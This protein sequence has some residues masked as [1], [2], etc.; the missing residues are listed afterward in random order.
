MSIPVFPRKGRNDMIGTRLADDIARGKTFATKREFERWERA[1][2]ARHNKDA[3]RYKALM[4]SAETAAQRIHEAM[5]PY[6]DDETIRRVFVEGMQYGYHANSGWSELHAD[7]AS[8]EKMQQVFGQNGLSGQHEDVSAWKKSLVG[9]VVTRAAKSGYNAGG[10]LA[11]SAQSVCNT[12]EQWADYF[13]V[14]SLEYRTVSGREMSI[15]DILADLRDADQRDAVDATGFS[16]DFAQR[17]RDVVDRLVVFY[18][19]HTLRQYRAFLRGFNSGYTEAP[20]AAA[21]GKRAASSSSSSPEKRGRIESLLGDIEQSYS[22]ESGMTDENNATLL[23]QSLGATF[24]RN[25][26]VENK[27]LALQ[28]L[29]RFYDEA[30]SSYSRMQRFPIFMKAGS[31]L[32]PIFTSKKINLLAPTTGEEFD[33]VFPGVMNSIDS[34]EYVS[35]FT[36]PALPVRATILNEIFTAKYGASSLRQSNEDAIFAVK[37]IVNHRLGT[38]VITTLPLQFKDIAVIQ[39]H[40]LTHATSAID[41]NYAP[42]P[43]QREMDTIRACD[44]YARSSVLLLEQTLRDITTLIFTPLLINTMANYVD[45]TTSLKRILALYPPRQPLDPNVHTFLSRY[46]KQLNE[47]WLDSRVYI[48]KSVMFSSDITRLVDDAI[49]SEVAFYLKNPVLENKRALVAGL[50]KYYTTVI[51]VPTDITHDEYRDTVSEMGT[52]KYLRT[53]TR[54]LFSWLALNTETYWPRDLCGMQTVI[55]DV[56]MLRHLREEMRQRVIMVESVLQFDR[57][58]RFSRWDFVDHLARI[59][60]STLSAE[61]SVSFAQ[62]VQHFVELL[63]SNPGTDYD[64]D[65]PAQHFVSPAVHRTNYTV[66][67]DD[68]VGFDSEVIDDDEE[69]GYD[70]DDYSSHHAVDDELDVT[71]EYTPENK[72]KLSITRGFSLSPTS[73]WE[74]D[75]IDSPVSRPSARASSSDDSGSTPIGEC[76]A[77]HAAS[78]LRARQRGVVLRDISPLEAKIEYGMAVR[79]DAHYIGAHYGHAFGPR[80]GCAAYS[81]DEKRTVIAEKN[82]PGVSGV[83]AEYIGAMY[84][85]ARVDIGTTANVVSPPQEP[86]HDLDID[87]TVNYRPR[88]AGHDRETPHGLFFYLSHSFSPSPPVFVSASEAASGKRLHLQYKVR[89]PE[90]TGHAMFNVDGY[91]RLVDVDAEA[92]VNQAGFASIR[93]ADL[94]SNR[95]TSFKLRVP[96]SDLQVAKG[97]VTLTVHSASLPIRTDSTIKSPT[98]LSAEYEQTQRMIREYITANR[99]FYKS[100]PNVVESVQNITVFEYAA[101]E[102]VI[103][104]SLFDS[105]KL[106]PTAE[107]YFTQALEYVLRRRR[108]DADIPLDEWT[109]L[110]KRTKTVALM[111]VMRLYVNYCTYIRDVVDNNREDKRWDPSAIELIE[112]FDYIRQRDAGDCEDFT[113]EILQAAMELKHN[114]RDSLSPAIQE[115]RKIADEFV[116][117]SVLCGVSR[118]AMSL[119]ELSKGRVSL[120]GHECAVAIPSYVFFEALRRN[121]PGH[122]AFELYSEEEQRAGADQQ[123]FVLEGTGCLFPEPRT[124]TDFFKQ[125][126]SAFRRATSV[127]K[128]AEAVVFYHP[129][130]DDGFY[131]Q[132]ITILTPELFLRTGHLG[133]EFLVC[134]RT[135]DGLKRGVPFSLLLDIHS[136]AEIQIVPAPAMSP[137]VFRASSRMD[138]DDFP[139]ISLE[140]GVVTKEMKD[141]C[142]ALTTGRP[143]A[144]QD[145]FQFHVKFSNMISTYIAAIKQFAQQNRLS[146][147][148]LAESVKVSFST[149]QYVGGYTILLF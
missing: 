45:R 19:T 80:L 36:P 46:V 110:D 71:Q 136:H 75:P 33:A 61:E 138:D 143:R 29:A 87:V 114:L 79:G 103:P 55:H 109:A 91:A 135:P 116:F 73:S 124:K 140:P 74:L 88:L 50:A 60:Q 32:R 104:G 40:L 134:S 100:H 56:L 37:L 128:R 16:S 137:E 15:G 63:Q 127:S 84:P 125:V 141:V 117:A 62:T 58:G 123:I 52:G 126:E 131:K 94:V 49:A 2:T 64:S 38:G 68:A 92:C 72:Q 107:R 139:P 118:E 66:G 59:E 76:M 122:P 144:G 112:S 69:D 20:A 6:A 25:A 34:T 119:A 115:M 130:Q 148:C 22:S 70:T 65:S 44:F 4:A 146:V 95:L 18:K 24:Y 101:R 102:G 5:A 1:L 7:R 120:H 41:D 133:F 53:S 106:A 85:D 90:I 43:T 10:N 47:R 11:K 21:S 3:K 132:M 121:D 89:Y 82:A 105:F 17:V 42:T 81:R 97:D 108:P 27:L 9:D 145:F 12:E 31:A 54:A 99:A 14:F 77:C 78:R 51:N 39:R 67:A 35:R 28:L 83:L 57:P 142:A 147:L 96:N 30:M 86:L 13:T 113:R 149:G 48:S 111:D 129:S 93:L 98:A 23:G 8:T 26:V